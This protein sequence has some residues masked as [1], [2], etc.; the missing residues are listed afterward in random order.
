LTQSGADVDFLDYELFIMKRTTGHLP[1]V[2]K[3][4]SS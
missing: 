3:H 1:F 2:A 4:W